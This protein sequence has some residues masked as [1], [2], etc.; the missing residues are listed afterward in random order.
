MEHK[1]LKYYSL[2]IE[3]KKNGINI[4]KLFDDSAMLKHCLVTFKLNH[5]LKQITNINKVLR[6]LFQ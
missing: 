4:E 2:F 3:E 5:N 1:L 6:N